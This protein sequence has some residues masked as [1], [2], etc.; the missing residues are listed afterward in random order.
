L[1]AVK[2]AGNLPLVPSPAVSREQQPT[3]GICN[4]QRAPL[5]AQ[6]SGSG[7][8][9]PRRLKETA[10]RG[11]AAGRWRRLGLAAAPRG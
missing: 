5:V 2:T 9:Q 7:E 8:Q 10:T 6:R 4:E 11:R 3:G 1:V